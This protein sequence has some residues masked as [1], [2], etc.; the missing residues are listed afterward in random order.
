MQRISLHVQRNSLQLQEQKFLTSGV[1]LHLGGLGG[2]WA[3]ASDS[4]L[5]LFHSPLIP[6]S[7]YC[8]VGRWVYGEKKGENIVRY[9]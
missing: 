1:K 2:K 3:V 8:Q 6:F 5:P 9:I 4:I 7:P